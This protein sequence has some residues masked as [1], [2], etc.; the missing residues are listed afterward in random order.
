MSICMKYK[1]LCIYVHPKEKKPLF[2]AVISKAS[3]V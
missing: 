3:N 2:D 1:I